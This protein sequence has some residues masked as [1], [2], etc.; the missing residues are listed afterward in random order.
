MKTPCLSQLL[1]PFVYVDF[2]LWALAIKSGFRDITKSGLPAITN[3][4]LAMI[5]QRCLGIINESLA[6]SFSLL[7]FVF[8]CAF[9]CLSVGMVSSRAVEAGQ[10][11]EA[12]QTHY[13]S[14]SGNEN[15]WSVDEHQF[16]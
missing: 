7:S 2:L 10:A 14:V 16:F 11:M 8:V 1:T 5:K 15:E 13:N 12:G 9:V 3:W 6:N 4:L